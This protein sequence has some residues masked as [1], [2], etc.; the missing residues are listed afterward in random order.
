[1][2]LIL[3]EKPLAGERIARILSGGKAKRHLFRKHPY[4]TFK[5]RGEDAVLVPL[6]GHILDVD[7][8]EEFSRWKEED[9]EKLVDVP[10]KQVITE[11]TVS[12]LLRSLAPHVDTIIIATDADREGE[13]IGLE[14]AELVMKEKGKRVP[15][16]R[17]RFSAI[18][19]QEILKAFESLELPDRN[20]AE[21]AFARREIDLLWGAVLTRALSLLTGRRGKEFLS[22][23]R[24]QSPTLALVV[25]REREIEQFKPIPYWVLE[26][27]LE[28]DGKSFKATYAEGQIWQEFMAKMLYQSVEGAKEGE[29]FRLERREENVARPVPFDTTTFLREANHLLGLSAAEAMAIA[30][31][32]YMKGLI[33]YPRTDNQSYPPSLDLREIVKMLAKI[34]EYAPYA[35]ELL[36]QDVFRPSSGRKTEDHPP[37]HPVGVPEKLSRKEKAV[38]DLIV[39]RFLATLFPPGI[40]ERVRVHIRINGVPFV[41]ESRRIIQKG[42][43]AVYPNNVKESALPPL[44]RGDI[45]AVKKVQLLKKQTQPPKRFSQGELVRRMEALML[46]TKS[47]RAEIVAKLFARKYIQGKKAIRP[48]ELGKTL[49]EVLSKYAP[50]IVTPDMTAKLEQ[51]L[52]KIA[53]G[54]KD[55]ESVVNESRKLLRKVLE[56]ILQRKGDIAASFGEK[57]GAAA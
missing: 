3:A 32:L 47:T 31:E 50:D 36:M 27:L 45:L 9:L 1:M 17:A 53:K 33:S 5:F 43:L 11:K 20:L 34:P 29:V 42:W 19:K 55:K 37:I 16:Y 57:G 30:E 41:A 44:Q 10:L 21:S 52:E 7:F 48:T 22:V 49:V 38:Y 23:G 18:T 54:E 26:A 13:A 12:A 14:A 39:R 28:K 35:Q 2:I 46:G 4:W 40:I 15:V 25:E 56:E 6:K 24:V 8:P 51:E